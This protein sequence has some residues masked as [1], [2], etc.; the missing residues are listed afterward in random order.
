MTI[1]LTK[2]GMPEVAVYPLALVAAMTGAY[3]LRGKITPEWSFWVVEGILA[4]V[5]IWC[6][7]FFRDPKR[8]P[9][10]DENLLLSPADGKI[11]DIETLKEHPDFDG[12]VMR[13]GIFLSVFNVHINRMPCSGEVVKV[14]YKEGKF[15]NALDPDSA[16]ENESNDVYFKRSEQPNDLLIVRQIS[17]AIARRIVC[18]AEIGEKFNGGQQFGMIKFGSRSELYVP[19]VENLQCTV[20]V[21]DK[22]KAGLSVLAK[23]EDQ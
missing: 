10:E 16:R 23:Y 6:L 3:F 13:I 14:I 12:P 5:L 15:K 11:S 8:K 1:R 2:Y 22:V 4:V 17:G 19:A 18:R 21:G 20:N 7:S 9:P